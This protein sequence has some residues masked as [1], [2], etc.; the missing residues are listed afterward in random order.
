MKQCLFLG[1]VTL[2]LTGCYHNVVRSEYPFT[3]CFDLLIA[4]CNIL[5]AQ[6]CLTQHLVLPP[7]AIM[8]HLVAPNNMAYTKNKEWQHLHFKSHKPMAYVEV[9]MS[10]L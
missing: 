5:V 2:R 7:R 3:L 6:K 4:Y 8:S 1:L 9:I 10:N